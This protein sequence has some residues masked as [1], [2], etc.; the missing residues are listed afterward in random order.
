VISLSETNI[1]DVKGGQLQCCSSIKNMTQWTEDSS[2]K[3]SSPET[4]AAV[5]TTEEE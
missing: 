4:Y 3:S 5:K 1:Q 2:A